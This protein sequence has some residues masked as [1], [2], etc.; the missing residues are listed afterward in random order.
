MAYFK[1]TNERVFQKAAKAKD[2]DGIFTHKPLKISNHA[3]KI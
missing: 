1:L 2:T 3:K